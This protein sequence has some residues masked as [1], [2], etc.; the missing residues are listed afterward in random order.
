MASP[1]K[2][3]A[4]NGEARGD[5][6]HGGAGEN[7]QGNSGEQDDSADETNHDAFQH[8][9]GIVHPHATG[10]SA[11]QREITIGQDDLVHSW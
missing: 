8:P 11:G 6:D 9:Q 3:E 1:G 4:E 7:D 10:G 5:D 2:F